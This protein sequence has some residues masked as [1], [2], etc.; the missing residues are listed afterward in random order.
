MGKYKDDVNDFLMGGEKIPSCS[1]LKIGTKY[2]GEILEMAQ[3]QQRDFKTNKPMTWDDGS[4]RMQAVITLQTEENDPE[5]EDDDGR[6]N[7]YLRF[8]AKDAVAA[9]IREAKAE[10]NGLEIGG[11]L[12][13]EFTKQDKPKKR[14]ESGTKYFE[15]YY[16]PPDEN[17]AVNEYLQSDDPDGEDGDEDGQRVHEP[18]AEPERPKSRS[19]GRSTSTAKAEPEKPARGRGRPAASES[20]G[21]GRGSS[22]RG[23]GRAASNDGES[24]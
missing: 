20:S 13:I 12:E 9:A 16:E 15:A 23:R 24:F 2:A 10:D 18:E 22:A 14:G 7:L 4:P 1:F 6:R 5:I 21:R 19:R 3:R 8:K 17:A 11:W